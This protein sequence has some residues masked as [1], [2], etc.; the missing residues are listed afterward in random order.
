MPATDF[1]ILMLP[2]LENLKHGKACSMKS[3]KDDLIRFVELSDEAIKTYYL[4]KNETE[5]YEDIVQAKT[6]LTNADLIKEDHGGNVMITSLGKMVINKRLN[7][8]DIAY[9]R[10]FPGYSDKL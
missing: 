9:L 6:H 3:I 7:S 4:S 2:F 10:L 1:Q 5:F 8:I